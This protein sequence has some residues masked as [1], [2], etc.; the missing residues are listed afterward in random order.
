MSHPVVV[1]LVE[2]LWPAEGW[3]WAIGLMRLDRSGS[4]PIP[5]V[6]ASVLIALR[7]RWERTVD[8]GADG[9]ALIF[10]PSGLVL[11]ADGHS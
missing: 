8:A 2:P 3:E 9:Y 7:A 1:D 11:G 4:K 10:L 6:D 5:P